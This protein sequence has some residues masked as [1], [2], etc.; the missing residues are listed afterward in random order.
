MGAHPSF[1][2]SH[3]G[4]ANRSG[5]ISCF[6]HSH[7]GQPLLWGEVRVRGILPQAPE[8]VGEAG[9]KRGAWFLGHRITEL[10]H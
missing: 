8:V 7:Q 5:F 10:S 6:N 1:T 9:F 3:W 2:I 4:R